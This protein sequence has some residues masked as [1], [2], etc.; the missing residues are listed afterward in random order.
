MDRA[1]LQRAR[2]ALRKPPHALAARLLQES[3]TELERL[4][5][6]RRAAAFDDAALLRA[7]RAGSPDELWDRTVARSPFAHVALQVDDAERRR[8]LDAADDALARRVDLLGSGPCEL[9]R[10]IDWLRD[11]KTGH[12]WPSGY[13]PR[14]EYAN[15]DRPSDVKLPW[16]ISRVQ[17][18]LPAGQAYIL[19]GDERY[20]EAARD[21]LDEWIAANP[22]AGTVNWS[23]TMEVALRILSW[24]WLLGALGTS[25]SWRDPGFRGR[26]LRTLWLHGDYTSRHLERSDVNGNHF[27]ADAAGLTFAGLL[28]DHEPWASE[29][30]RLLVEELPRQVYDDGVDFEASAVYHRLVHELFLLPA[31]Y[32]EQLELPGPDAYRERLAAMAVFTQAIAHPDGTAPLWGDADDGRALP[33]AGEER[34]APQRRSAAFPRGGVYVLARGNDHVFVDCGPVGLA[35]RGG[36]GHNDCLSFEATLDGTKLVT[37]CG[38]Y[39]YTA[40]PEW[41][42]RFRATAAHNTPQIDQ[43]EQNRIP[44]SLWL[45]ENDARPQPLLVEEL[46]FRGGHTGYLRLADPVRPVRTIALEPELHALLVHDAF[47]ACAPHDVEIPFHLADGIDAGEPGPGSLPLGRFVLQ[48]RSPEPWQCEIEDAWVSP[49]YGVKRPIHRVTFRR[50]GAVAPLTV[51]IA[52]AGSPEATVWAWAEEVATSEPSR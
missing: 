27:T 46:R 32:R 33:L 7:A 3:R 44:G 34:P 45:L 12:R 20:A 9:G 50:S 24:S 47:E 4:L 23:V 16:E 11:P 39:V 28:F 38:S 1:T 29:G 14:L 26:F 10:P 22:Y 40:S 37:D 21:V 52:P 31:L 5:A 15:L 48:W 41:R 8:V 35:G 13:A 30:W 2:H 51:V 43:A 42:N 36:H 18:L 6:P 17:W 19:T 49:S 25:A